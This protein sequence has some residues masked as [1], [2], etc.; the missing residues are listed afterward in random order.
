MV[1]LLGTSK[2]AF[3]LP[4]EAGNRLLY[5][6]TRGAHLKIENFIVLVV[7]LSINLY[8]D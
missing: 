8:L 4:T 3:P 1:L 7:R 5:T 6:S 2:N